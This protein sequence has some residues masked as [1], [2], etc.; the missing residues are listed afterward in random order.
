MSGPDIIYDDLV[1]YD[2]VV[3]QTWRHAV[4]LPGAESGCDQEK[5]RSQEKACVSVHNA[6][7]N[8]PTI[9]TAKTPRTKVFPCALCILAV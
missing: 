3:V 9:S 5:Q 1:V 4:Q 8:H 7:L 6:V 2:F